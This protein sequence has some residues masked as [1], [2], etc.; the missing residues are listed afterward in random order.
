[1]KNV[2]KFAA[3]FFVAL[4]FN[5]CSSDDDSPSSSAD[6]IV[7][8]WNQTEYKLPY[9]NF[10]GETVEDTIN[11]ADLC[12]PQP[13]AN[14]KEDGSLTFSSVTLDLDE[15]ASCES[16]DLLEG[17]WGKIDDSNYTLNLNGQS[18]SQNVE[19]TFSNNNNT[20]VLTQPLDETN[21]GGQAK[22]TLERQ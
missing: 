17:Q 10:D 18:Q 6:L 12:D 7:G 9:E 20:M 5:A 13:I 14:F 1:M 15:P 22:I 4:S 11:V 2:L 16:V 19:I 21:G 8:N 3:V